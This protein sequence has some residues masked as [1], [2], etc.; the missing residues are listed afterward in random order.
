MVN[1]IG[2]KAIIAIFLFFCLQ[3]FAFTQNRVDSLLK[4][5]KQTKS[6]SSIYNQ[7]SEATLEDSH[8]LSMRYARQ[9]LENAESEKNI[10][11]KGVALF[12]IAEAF[13]IE[14]Q[15]DSAIYFYTLAI[16]IFKQIKDDY[17]TSYTLNNLG[18]ISNEYGNF[19][20]AIEYYL[21]STNYL[22][23]EIHKDDLAH[24]Y[25]NIGNSHHQL[26]NYFTA[27]EYFNNSISIITTIEDKSSLPVAW[28]GIGLAYKY[29]AN[30]DS[31]L[32]YYRMLLDFDK[33]HGT[34][35]GIAIDHQ[36]I[37]S[38][39]F[40]W[41]QYDLAEEYY[42]HAWQIYKAKGTKNDVSIILNNLGKVSQ[43]RREFKQALDFYQQALAIDRETGIKSNI[44]I[45][46]NNL[47]TVYFEMKQYTEA[48]NYFKK[49]LAIND[50]LSQ[51]YNKGMNYKNLGNVYMK[52]GNYKT[53][54]DV[55]KKGLT[56]ASETR[57]K[58]LTLSILESFAGLYKTQGRYEEAYDYFT[59]YAALKDSLFNENNQRALAD[60]HAKYEV[61][62]K[63]Q[64]II[65][66]NKQ[67]EI[68]TIRTKDYKRYSFLL[69]AGIIIISLL[70]IF[71][72]RQY[73]SKN[74]AYKKLVSQ[75][76]ELL[77]HNGN[78][79]GQF[80]YDEGKISG[81]PSIYS[82]TD[83]KQ[84]QLYQ[85]LIAYLK[86]EK[87]YLREDLNITDVAKELETNAHYISEVINKQFNNNFNSL[88]NDYRI[89]EAC[90]LFSDPMNDNL[91]IES[92][93]NQSGFK[94]KSV[95]NNAFKS[96]T[97][98]TPSF[99]RKTVLKK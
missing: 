62:K 20:Q 36:N 55:L 77:K 39:Y 19:K 70:S 85:N 53:A 74:R 31:A 96:V 15:A 95:F 79:N 80:Q 32:Y 67:K 59:K 47:G 90:R 89:K 18:W 86:K 8:E 61:D 71:L 51:Q 72:Y 27:I 56:I 22:D 82:L 64:E 65:L 58:N 92:I 50:S 5:L 23:D 12:N 44:A 45:R 98:L 99:Y 46:F 1:H 35:R 83:T 97:G 49:S 10:R 68:E 87:A 60:M 76:M 21:E 52:S 26:G 9:A 2:T 63:D 11:E 13:V 93:G 30:Y 43:A 40:D 6:K 81:E 78:T 38:L 57:S 69:V 48:E 7:L 41:H 84:Q 91:T 34:E 25:I 66:L 16:P 94:S 37:G 73:R 28:N 3:S 75:N 88:I 33:I 4:E 29:L 42:R 54:E 14:Y 24:V 17:N